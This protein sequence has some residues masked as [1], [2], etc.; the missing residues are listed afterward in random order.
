M[1]RIAAGE[2]N[3]QEKYRIAVLGRARNHLAPIAAAL[4]EAEI[5]FRAVELEKLAAR[6]EVLD[7]LA[8][9]RALLNPQDRVAWLGVLRAPWCGLSLDDLH[10]LAG[11]DD[12]SCS[13]APC[14]SCSPSGCRCSAKPAAPAPT[15]C[16]SQSLRRSALR[17]AQP[18]PRWEPGWSRSG[19]SWAARP[20]WTRPPAPTSTCSGVAWTV[21]PAANKICSAPRLD[22]ALDKLTALPD[23]E[24]SSDCGVQ[25]MTIHKSKGLE[26]EVVIVPELQ[27]ASGRGSR[28]ML[29]WLERGLAEPD[30]SGEIT[31]F[32]IAPFQRKGEDRGKAKAWVDRVYR[33]RESQET[34]RILYVAATRARE[35]LHLFA[36]PAC[37]EEGGEL[38]AGGTL[39]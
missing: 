27:A 13:L 3:A 7:A 29:S 36:R 10:S 12:P 18:A 17:A 39:Q 15:A 5:P 1:D 9:A 14:R 6:P 37:K 35:E 20:A 25:L 11:A 2:G 19:C 26:F 34:R 22:A 30:E 16:C 21:S 33:E 8:L 23:P 4:R 38:H 28:K 24:A 31:E 32:L